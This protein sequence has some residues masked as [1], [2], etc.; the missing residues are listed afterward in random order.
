M[1][2]K[3]TSVA[4]SLLLLITAFLPVH[5][6]YAEGGDVS[7]TIVDNTVEVID[8]ETETAEDIT[9]SD[10]ETVIPVEL[11][12]EKDSNGGLIISSAD[13]EFIKEIHDNVDNLKV[14]FI[15][16]SGETVLLDSRWFCVYSSM[17][18]AGIFIFSDSFLKNGILKDTDYTV[19]FTGID[20]SKD[21][22]IE[23]VQ[24]Y[25]ETGCVPHPDDIEISQDSYGNLIVSSTDTDYLQGL[26][27]EEGYD[28]NNTHVI[29]Y[30]QAG[31]YVV[32]NYSGN[33]DIVF[34]EDNSQVVISKKALL[35][36]GVSNGLLKLSLN[37]YGYTGTGIIETEVKNMFKDA[38]AD[39]RVE[40]DQN[41]NFLIYSSDYDYL[42]NM[43]SGL[44]IV[45]FD[46]KTNNMAGQLILDNVL[47][48]GDAIRIPFKNF[49]KAGLDSGT[50]NVLLYVDGYSDNLLTNSAF[51][52]KRPLDATLNMD[53]EGNFYIEG[54]KE[55]LDLL[56]S[57]DEDNQAE[58]L[59]TDDPETGHAG[60]GN[61]EEDEAFY[62]NDEKLYINE[63]T[64]LE[65]LSNCLFEPG[66]Q[67]IY[68]HFELPEDKRTLEKSILYNPENDPKGLVILNRADE[69]Y[70]YFE[71]YGNLGREFMNSLFEKYEMFDGIFFNNCIY[72]NF[73]DFDN[74]SFYLGNIINNDAN[75]LIEK[76]N[77]STVRISLDDLKRYGFVSGEYNFYMYLNR[78]LAYFMHD[79][80]LNIGTDL[81][82]FP[83]VDKVY[84]DDIVAPSVGETIPDSIKL[85]AR[86]ADGN[87]IDYIEGTWT[88]YSEEDKGYK[89]AS[90]GV[91]EKDKKYA[92]L[93]SVRYQNNSDIEKTIF[94]YKGKEFETEEGK[95]YYI[96][97]TSLTSLSTSYTNIPVSLGNNVCINYY[98]D[99][100]I[101]DPS[102]P[103][104]IEGIT[105]DIAL[106]NPAKSGYTFAGWYSNPEF[107][108]SKVTKISK[109]TV[110]SVSLYAKW[111][112]N[113][114]K[115]VYNLSGGS[116]N[117]GD[118]L[119]TVTYKTSDVV[120][121]TDIVPVKA[122]YE[123]KG[124]A[125]P[126]GGFVESEFSYVPASNNVSLTL[127]AV[128]NPVEY[129]I[130]LDKEGGTM[131]DN[132]T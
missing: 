123:F 84:I 113:T 51:V 13:E 53:S 25:L 86:D 26:A 49:A 92:I 71:F 22:E 23:P 70:L 27:I 17:S 55:L 130:T 117:K 1:K 128:W 35:R 33:I 69:E 54:D 29:L 30:L 21:Y 20:F 79:I 41:D 124:W 111:T 32:N 109:N 39:V 18:N 80:E 74:M 127:Y 44:N 126:D 31:E 66:D 91:F 36:R 50:Y 40:M 4:I 5:T 67:N 34:D 12:A 77:Q 90:G 6:V 89:W 99:G 122:G 38:P 116:L 37:V 48:Y 10:A 95:N 15:S 97:F 105:K 59:V 42:Y 106:K 45:F 64:K 131:A 98:L 118:K 81:D 56:L 104:N 112:E 46:V 96:P 75:P 9:V 129:S 94:V 24:V 100:G 76:I 57:M 58:L 121:P 47:R 60:Y 85:T 16:V 52:Y 7:E 11:S 93:A 3:I 110:G 61:R 68:Y 132:Q 83:Q 2:M 65:I 19:D 119:A 87:Q 107:K 43:E 125:Y 102:N 78:E 115:L 73:Y 28:L 82:D 114:Y 108:G 8:E 63:K 72:T 101:N 62:I 103:V 14:R 88:V 120:S